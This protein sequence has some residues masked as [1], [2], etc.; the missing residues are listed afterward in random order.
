VSPRAVMLANH[1]VRVAAERCGVNP[2]LIVQRVKGWVKCRE[3]GRCR[4]CRR[5]SSVRPLTRHHLVPLS[6]FRERERFA[7]LRNV[8]ANI[9]PL[10]EACHKQIERREPA[11]AR[12][13]LRRLLYPS[14]V[15]FV[16]QTAG[17]GWLDLRY[18]PSGQESLG[19]G[20]RVASSPGVGAKV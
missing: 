16:L 1:P 9:I 20:L 5:P 17:R 6:W 7:P 3:E 8:D 14:E 13:E 19:L 4:M 2:S 10:C 11:H 12:V 15:A 18:P